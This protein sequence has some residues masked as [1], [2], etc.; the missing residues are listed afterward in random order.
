MTTT[1]HVILSRKATTWFLI[2]TK[3]ANER[4]EGTGMD[5][6]TRWKVDLQATNPLGLRK[7][8]NENLVSK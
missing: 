3:Y 2:Q 4:K 5:R 7:E 6:T 1:L 8:N